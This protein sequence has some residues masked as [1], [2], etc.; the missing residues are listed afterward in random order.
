MILST[1]IY[2]DKYPYTTDTLLRKAGYKIHLK[3]TG[4]NSYILEDKEGRFEAYIYGKVIDLHYDVWVGK[5]SHMVLPSDYRTPQEKN[6]LLEIMYQDTEK[7][8][9]ALKANR[10]K[11]LAER[12]KIRKPAKLYNS[13]KDTLPFNE[14]QKIDYSALGKVKESF[15]QSTTCIYLKN[16]IRYFHSQINTLVMTCKKIVR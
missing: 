8:W 15:P 12:G 11:Q 7:Y 2:A 16:M 9:K 13:K 6:R 14:I 4:I 3:K 1:R 10:L 5:T